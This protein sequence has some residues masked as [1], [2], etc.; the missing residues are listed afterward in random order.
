[1]K[2]FLLTFA[3]AALLFPCMAQK[4]WELRFGTGYDFSAGSQ[5]LVD[6]SDISSNSYNMKLVNASFGRGMDFHTDITRWVNSWLGF[7]AG[8]SYHITS[9]PVKG[10]YRYY[11]FEFSSSSNGV[12]HSHIA[13][14]AAAIALRV[15]NTRLHPYARLG[16][17]L[18]V[19]AR[20]TDDED[21]KSGGGF[22][23]FN[24]GS[25]KTVYRLRSTAGYMASL[26][27]APEISKH[28]SLFIDIRLLSQAILVRRSSLTSYKVQGVEKIDAY[29]TYAK[30]T[31]YV[32]KVDPTKPYHDYEPAEKL[33]FSLP[34]SSIGIHAGISFKL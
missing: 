17:V 16:V 25:S 8:G 31:I 21:W 32:K 34:Y 1:M 7:S 33:I 30:E 26:G 29:T 22:G 10:Y 3:F 23:G 12:W 14:A 13:E 24:Y 18:P 20:V 5:Y 27:I 6:Q 11:A 9:A 15:P 19:Y 4:Q 28:A 2:S